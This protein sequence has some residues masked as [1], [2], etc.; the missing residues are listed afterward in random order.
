MKKQFLNN[1]YPK[2]L[3]EAHIDEIKG[4]DFAPA[5]D[6]AAH[7]KEIQE[8]PD[9]NF[10]LSLPFTSMRCEKIQ[11][12]IKKIIKSFAPSYSLNF[13]WSSE[14]LSRFYNPLLKSKQD[15]FEKPGVVYQKTCNCGVSYIGETKRRLSSRIKEH[16]RPSCKTAI[17]EHIFN[18][19]LYCSQLDESHGDQL[20]PTVKFNFLKDHFKV[21]HQN[22][23]KYNQRKTFE[24]VC[25][26]MLKPKLN[27]Q[28][29]SRIVNFI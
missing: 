16:G 11:S 22:L 27:E 29:K 23:N 18:C 15:P 13:A 5:F 3:I 9:R 7:E 10:T 6:R 24:A 28:V 14:R 8:N 12:N 19:P 4:R 2:T 25:I 17:S 21:L 1:N 20:N 26:K